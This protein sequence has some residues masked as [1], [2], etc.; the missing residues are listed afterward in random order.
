MHD[1][2]TLSEEVRDIHGSF[3]TIALIFS[4]FR[5][6]LDNNFYSHPQVHLASNVIHGGLTLS[7]TIELSL[8]TASDFLEEL[9]NDKN[10]P[11]SFFGSGILSAE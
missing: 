4:P 8:S 1:M 9:R 5:A 10:C 7:D 3:E 6:M 11:D 2:S